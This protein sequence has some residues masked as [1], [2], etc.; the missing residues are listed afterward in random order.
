V[1]VV[2][3]AGLEA[4]GYFLSGPDPAAILRPDASLRVLCHEMYH[5]L[6]ATSDAESTVYAYRAGEADADEF[7]SVLC[8]SD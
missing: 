3:L 8:G 2:F 1:A 7:A 5:S 6:T 4:P